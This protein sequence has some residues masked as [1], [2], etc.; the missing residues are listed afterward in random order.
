MFDKSENPYKPPQR[1]TVSF[2]LFR[3]SKPKLSITVLLLAFLFP[4]LAFIPLQR[5]VL[6][7][8]V[9][10]MPAEYQDHRNGFFVP[11]LLEVF[12]TLV[13]ISSSTACATLSLSNTFPRLSR[14]LLVGSC[15]FAGLAIFLLSHIY[16]FF[17]TEG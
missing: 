3:S 6:G 10:F 15:I 12:F 14:G 16:L 8:L 9:R 5:F 1:E 4:F 7:E 11:L 13:V 2:E 17:Y